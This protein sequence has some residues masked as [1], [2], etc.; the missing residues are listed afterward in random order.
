MFV[1]FVIRDGVLRQ[2]RKSNVA[3]DVNESCEGMASPPVAVVVPTDFKLA[4]LV[5]PRETGA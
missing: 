5:G 2:R 1:R 3:G 4:A